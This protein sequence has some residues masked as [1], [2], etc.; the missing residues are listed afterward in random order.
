M[1]KFTE[2]RLGTALQSGLFL[3]SFLL[4]R[5]R[6]ESEKEILVFHSS[7]RFLSSYYFFLYYNK[8][9]S[10]EEE[11]ELPA[12]KVKEETPGTKENGG[13]GIKGMEA[14]ALYLIT[15]PKTVLQSSA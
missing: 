10:Q 11:A 2:K 9:R 6:R 15:A 14:R 5:E 8:G 7:S 1:T 12:R 3:N 13:A 4:N